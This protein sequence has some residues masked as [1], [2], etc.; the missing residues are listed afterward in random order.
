M[1]EKVNQIPQFLKS[2]PVPR[3]DKIQKRKEEKKEM[4]IFKRSQSDALQEKA[5][6]VHVVPHL[7]QKG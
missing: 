3:N 2:A 5:F 6:V 7:A 4:N 1:I